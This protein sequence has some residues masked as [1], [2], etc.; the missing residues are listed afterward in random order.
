MIP[1]TSH[2]VEIMMRISY[3]KMMLIVEE[4]IVKPS[5]MSNLKDIEVMMVDINDIDEF[6]R[7]F[8]GILVCNPIVT[9]FSFGR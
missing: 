2:D 5:L 6:K 1:L 8:L 3:V 9:Y 4:T 7:L